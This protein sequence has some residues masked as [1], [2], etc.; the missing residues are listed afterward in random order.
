MRVGKRQGCLDALL[1]CEHHCRLRGTVDAVHW[2]GGKEGGR[3]N[4][5]T[6]ARETD[7]RPITGRRAGWDAR[8]IEV[9]AKL[10]SCQG[11]DER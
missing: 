5:R 10:T 4:R 11:V 1:R 7:G 3:V 6:G 8:R 2:T 9:I